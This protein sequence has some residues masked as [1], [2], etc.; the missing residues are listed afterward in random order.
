MA[1]VSR[2]RRRALRRTF[3]LILL[4]CLGALAS[5]AV[6]RA[7]Q[8]ALVFQTTGSAYASPAADPAAEASATAR[9]SEDL[10]LLMDLWGV[11]GG[12]PSNISYLEA[13]EGIRAGQALRVEVRGFTE[14]GKPF[15]GALVEVSWDLGGARYKDFTY[16]S[17]SGTADV[18]RRLD[19]SCQGKRCIVAVRIY[20]DDLQGMAYSTFVAR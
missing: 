19:K 13:P 12:P 16:T 6:E 5:I 11:A 8:S 4:M 1:F 14:D 7:Q 2:V 20:R 9:L 17:E 3:L 10:P 15:S 18:T